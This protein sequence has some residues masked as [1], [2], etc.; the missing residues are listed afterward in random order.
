[1]VDR[2]IVFDLQN[3][4]VQIFSDAVCELNGA[5]VAHTEVPVYAGAG[6]QELSYIQ[7]IQQLNNGDLGIMLIILVV[8][9]GIFILLLILLGKCCTDKKIAPRAQDE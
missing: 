6:K 2:D 5:R 3:K 8:I 9:I 1:M 7:A 4:T